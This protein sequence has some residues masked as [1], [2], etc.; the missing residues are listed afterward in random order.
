[1]SLLKTLRQNDKQ[2]ERTT[3]HAMAIIEMIIQISVLE[4]A[5]MLPTITSVLLAIVAVVVVLACC[6]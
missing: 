5:I 1:M 2:E 3:R 4:M 6:C